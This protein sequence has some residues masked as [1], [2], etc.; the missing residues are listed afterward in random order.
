MEDETDGRA[1]GGERERP[2]EAVC[3]SGCGLRHRELRIPIF[4]GS[5]RKA[6]SDLKRV[7]I[8]GNSQA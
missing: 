6:G 2:Q 5:K 4:L 8:W 7:G 3:V 1:V